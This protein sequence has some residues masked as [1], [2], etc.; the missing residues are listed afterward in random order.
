MAAGKALGESRKSDIRRSFTKNARKIKTFRRF[1]PFKLLNQSETDIIMYH[2]K[3]LA[4]PSYN[5]WYHIN[6]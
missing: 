6:L 2:I 3:R 1:M 5:Q 4:L